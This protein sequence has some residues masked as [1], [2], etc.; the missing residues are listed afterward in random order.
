MKQIDATIYFG[1]E[2]ARMSTT[3]YVSDEATNE[4]IEEKLREEALSAVE[5]DWY[6]VT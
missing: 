2:G 3:I 6:E 1:V 4:E 5:F